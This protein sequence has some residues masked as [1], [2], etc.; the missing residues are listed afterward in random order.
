MITTIQLRDA[1]STDLPALVALEAQF[2]S[3]Q[4]SPRQ[5]RA[6]LH[7]ANASFRIT[8]A[9]DTRDPS[10]Q[11]LGYSLVFYRRNSAVARLY[12]LAVSPDAQG[13]G[14][15]KRLLLDAIDQAMHRGATE[16]RLQVRVDNPAA[17]GLYETHGFIRTART[18]GYYEDGT[19]AWQ[20]AKMLAP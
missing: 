15:G 7:N 10:A 12:S 16:I 19:D 4:L 17:I 1:V 14:I 3:D 8:Q 11:L 2:T 5:L 18:P 9:M 6:H 13:Q 20:M